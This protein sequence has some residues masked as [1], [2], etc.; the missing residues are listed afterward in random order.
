M[1][2]F[3]HILVPRDFSTPARN[4][5]DW[6]V[7]WA[8]R[9]NARLTMMHVVTVFDD[10]PYNP[11]RDR[12]D[13]RDFYRKIEGLADAQL[14]ETAP[15]SAG[16]QL[17]IDSVVRRG[18]SPAEELLDYASTNGVD[19][20][21]MGTHGRR[22]L[23][24]FLLGSVAERV[25]KHAQ[26]PVMTCRPPAEKKA[27]EKA[28]Q[29]ILVPTDFSEN[30][31]SALQLAKQLLPQDAELTVLHVIADTLHPAYYL[32]G[33]SSLF[34][35]L[36]DLEEHARNAMQRFLQDSGIGSETATVIMQE[37]DP[38]QRIIEFARENRADLI[39]MGSRG[40]SEWEQILVGSVTERVVRKAACPVLT[41]K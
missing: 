23:S 6:G 41:I 20:I 10:D 15:E 36:P 18:F 19:L 4:A 16:S 39:V 38:A 3:R 26:C 7:Y 8:R 11:Q 34:D 30:S 33:K 9:F 12:D 1:S 14:Q 2:T 31:K 21:V 35:L 40:L 32:A 25:I 17:E 22:A 29:R 13:W 37:G 28:V 27:A 24:R 5:L